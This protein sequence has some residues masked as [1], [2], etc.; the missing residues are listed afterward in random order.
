MIERK[1]A[2]KFYL[3]WF[4]IISR[5]CGAT[6]IAMVAVAVRTETYHTA[7]ASATLTPFDFTTL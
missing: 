2:I 7:V 1:K 5:N 6:G 3:V 4:K